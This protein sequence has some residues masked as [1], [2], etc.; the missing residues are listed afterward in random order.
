MNTINTIIRQVRPMAGELCDLRIENGAIAEIGSGLTPRANENVID[1]GSGLL[2]PGLVN[3]HAH[4]DKTFW[5]QPWQSHGAGPS[6][7]ERIANER[8]MLREL[9]LDVEAQSRAL[10]ER[11]VAG[12]TSHIRTHIDIDPELELRHFRAVASVRDALR[13]VV[14]M[15][16]VAFP[17]SGVM[18]AEG[19][20]PLLEQALREGAEVVGGVDPMGLDR[21]PTGQL[22]AIFGLAERYGAEVDIHLH[23]AGEMG[24]VTLEMI[25]ERTRALGMQGKVVV[26]HAFC[27][28]SVTPARFE[29]LAG[30][31]RDV[32]IAIMSHAP[33]GATSR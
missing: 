14:E 32:D 31:L 21:D 1:G 17:Q 18:R 10:I 33:S 25:V 26:S 8:R 2:L 29:Q 19:T 7:A 24:A 15:Q 9:A 22:D 20:V 6:V 4:V 27:L 28:A 23:D 12:G 16:V 5:S 3:A 30:L 13:D 11:M